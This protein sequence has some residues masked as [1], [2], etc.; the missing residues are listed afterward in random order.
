M[1][2]KRHQPVLWRLTCLDGWLG[3]N[4]SAERTASQTLLQVLL[5]QSQPELQV[6]PL[7][8]FGPAG[9]IQLVH[10]LVQR[11]L[12]ALYVTETHIHTQV[13][14]TIISSV[15]FNSKFQKNAYILLVSHAR[16]LI[17]WS[18]RKLTSHSAILA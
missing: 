4:G 12:P 13:T 5:D 8:L 7:G 14:L 17:R 9:L 6:H 18:R 16:S 10:T 1:H 3:L 15:K 11:G 2:E